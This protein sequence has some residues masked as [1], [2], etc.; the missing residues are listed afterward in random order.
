MQHFEIDPDMAPVAAMV[1][2]ANPIFAGRQPHHVGAALAD[3][4]ATWL[5]GHPAELREDLLAM[6]LEYVRKLTPINAAEIG[7]RP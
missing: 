2:A 6:H 7:N 5:A 4:V 3:L 1:A